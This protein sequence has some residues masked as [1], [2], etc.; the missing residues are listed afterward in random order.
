MNKNKKILLITSASILTPAS[1]VVAAQCNT[2]QKNS[3]TVERVKDLSSEE[4]QKLIA[5]TG[6]YSQLVKLVFG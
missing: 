3:Q 1:V 5:Q 6:D 4:F 2:S